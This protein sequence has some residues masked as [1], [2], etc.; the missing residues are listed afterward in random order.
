HT[1]SRLHAARTDL[2]SARQLLEERAVALAA[3]GGI[4]RLL[5]R[6]ARRT[7]IARHHTAVAQVERTRRQVDD[8]AQRRVELEDQASRRA[9][10]EAAHQ[11]E[12]NHHRKLGQAIT[13]RRL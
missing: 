13:Q 2:D 9:A 8:L 5:H 4:N 6:E 12:I 7:A 3:A 10:W 11:P 1:T